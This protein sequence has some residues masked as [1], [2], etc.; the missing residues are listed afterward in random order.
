[1]WGK[2]KLL[3][4]AVIFTAFCC[5]VTVQKSEHLDMAENAVDDL[6][7]GCSTQAF[8][9]FINGGLLEEEL[10]HS[11]EFSNAWKTK[12][13]SLKP[14][15]GTSKEH[16]MAL[17]AYCNDEDFVTTFNQAVKTLGA[18][19][20]KYKD[21]FHFKSFHFLLTDSMRQ[22]KSK[23]C[24]TVYALAEDEII[25]KNG[26]SVRFGRFLKASS[27]FSYVE[28]LTDLSGDFI[29][30]ITSCFFANMGPNICS[31]KDIVLLSPA[32]KFT[33]END[34]KVL[35]K[36]EESEYHMITLKH[37]NLDNFHNCYIFSRC[38]ADSAACWLVL[39]LAALAAWA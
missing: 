33:V 28:K 15:P 6:Y 26:S 31:D 20:E 35:Q 29:F 39:V 32:E 37:A 12:G 5:K 16:L 13:T 8:D 7:R 21:Q 30:N 27:N 1:M 11:E 23:D 36:K 18:D 2:R 3:L 19:A 38:T 34:G 22:L 25:A 14:I 9:M 17:R 10:N 24:K 4:S